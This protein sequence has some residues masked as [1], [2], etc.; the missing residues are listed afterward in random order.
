M[1]HGNRLAIQVLGGTGD[2]MIADYVHKRQAPPPS[3]SPT[4]LWSWRPGGQ[5]ASNV[6]PVTFFL[7][8]ALASSVCTYPVFL[9]I[10]T[11]PGQARLG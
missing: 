9:P 2:A 5:V 1:A 4:M 11:L 8:H 3:A 6:G 10:D 7:V